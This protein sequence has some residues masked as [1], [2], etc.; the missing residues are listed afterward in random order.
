MTRVFSTLCPVLLL[1]TACFPL[2]RSEKAPGGIPKQVRALFA[3]G[4]SLLVLPVWEKEPLVVTDTSGGASH[5]VEEALVVDAADLDSLSE[6]IDSKTTAMVVVGAGAAV[7][8]GVGFEGLYLLSETGRIAW[9]ESLGT[10]RWVGIAHHGR[11]G[12][13]WKTEL[14]R[15]FRD[16]EW[17]RD[18]SPLWENNRHAEG[19]LDL[20]ADDRDAAL[21]FVRSIAPSDSDADSWQELWLFPE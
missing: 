16:E 2:V 9:L 8:R 14:E 13:A 11:V 17:S 15:L 20:D 7:G 12:D 18:R 1:A 10:S 3:P 21:R 19:S 6:R 5:F 4:E